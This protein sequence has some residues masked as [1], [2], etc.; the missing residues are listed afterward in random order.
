MEKLRTHSKKEDAYQD[1]KLRY[2]DKLYELKKLHHK[3][4]LSGIEFSQEMALATDE[5][6]IN[7]LE[8]LGLSRLNGI[9]IIATGGYGRQELCPYSDIDLLFLYS[10]TKKSLVESTAEKLLYSLWDLNLQ[11]GHSIRTIDECFEMSLTEDTTI[12]TSLLDGRFITGDKKLYGKYHKELFFEFL[13]KVSSG[14]IERKLEENEQ[15][16]D[17]FGRSIYLLEPNIKEGEGG[18]RDIHSALWIAQAKFKL[19]EFRELIYKGIIT[20]KEFNLFK[21]GLDFLLQIRIH[22]HYLAGRAENILRFDYQEKVARFLGYKDTELPAVERF[23][24]IYYLRGNLI[25]EHS[26]KLIERCV[27]RPKISFSSQKTVVLDKGL[28]IQGGLLSASSRRIFRDHPQNFIKCFE[29]ADKYDLKMSK[30]LLD[31]IRENVKLID[32]NV[33]KDPGLNSSFLNL[34]GNGRA[35]S[36]ALFQMNRLRLLGHYIPEFGKIVCMVQHDAYHVYTVDIHS[37]FMIKE[38]EDLINGKYEQ[39]FSLL[40]KISRGI[41]KRHILHLAC[42]LHDIGKGEGRDHSQKGA[43]MIPKIAERIG[44]TVEESEKLQFIVKHHIIMPH[45]SQRRDLHDESLIIRFA[46]SVKTAETLSLLYLLSF[47]DIRS[48]GPDVWTNWKGMLL[49]ELYLRTAA[50][51]EEG[52]FKKESLDERASRFTGDVINLIKGE[53]SATWV[54]KILGGMP[55]SYFAGYSPQKIAYQLKLIKKYGKGVGMDVIFHPNEEYDEFTFWGFDK[56]GIFSQLCGVLAGNG[57]NI[58]GARIVTRDDGRILDVFYVNRLGKSTHM[59]KN[60]WSKVNEDLASVLKGRVDV[61][62]IVSRR[63]KY[64]PIYVKTIPKHAPRIEIDN[65]SS[66]SST[67]IDVYTYDRVGLL[68]DITKVITHLG[69]SITYAKISTKVDQVADVFYVN[70]INGGKVHDQNKLNQIKSIFKTIDSE[71]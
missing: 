41:S 6:I 52:E 28:I 46:K 55:D 62:E 27:F 32:E 25:R 30:Y 56:P 24:R 22:L 33:R 21:R 65:E 37:I 14:F 26:K 8:H 47:A 42:L 11:I 51:L 58:L 7:S 43:Q 5:L 67:I 59:E 53:I 40:T 57:I 16:I 44:L 39:E 71:D 4:A 60:L 23:M 64:K 38:I 68:Y 34:L 31:L 1:I 15:R 20:E 2:M 10:L 63:K 50:I 45:F 9:S 54:K 49:E 35:V 66:E 17:K 48:V 70:E 12:L 13:P 69:L 19:K 18:L 29:Y 3:K 61:G 36:D